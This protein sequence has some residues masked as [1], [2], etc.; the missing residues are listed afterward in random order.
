MI[1]ITVVINSYARHFSKRGASFDFAKQFSNGD[2]FCMTDNSCIRVYL[3]WDQTVCI[4]WI[5]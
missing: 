3:P 5:L 2:S 1:L 4:L